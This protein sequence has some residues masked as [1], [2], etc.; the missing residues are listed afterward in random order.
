MRWCGGIH[1][2]NRAAGYCPASKRGEV[3]KNH[4]VRRQALVQ[5]LT[6]HARFPVLFPAQAFFHPAREFLGL[7]TFSLS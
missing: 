7:Y 6:F 3:K 5:F 1:T 4:V 2:K